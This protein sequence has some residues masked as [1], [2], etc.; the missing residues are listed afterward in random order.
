MDVGNPDDRTALEAG[1]ATVEAIEARQS[2]QA[3]ALSAQ[4][5]AR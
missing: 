4:L 1:L 5:S 3:N 2:A